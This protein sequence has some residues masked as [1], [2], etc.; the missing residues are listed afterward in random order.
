MDILKEELKVNKIRNLYLFY[1]PEEY[2]KKYYLDAI[3]KEILKNDFT[4][5]NRTV[6]ENKTDT[7]RIIDAVDTLPAFS[8]K[9]LVIVKNSGLLK[10]KKS[11][12][13]NEDAK[14]KG[15]QDELL[16]YLQNMPEFAVL[17]FYE[18]EVDKRIKL[19]DAIKKNGL[20]VEF[21]FQKP[22]ELVKWVVKVFK[23]F[24]KEIDTVTAS[25]LVENSEQGM[26]E[27]LNEI[28]KLISFVGNRNIITL[29]DV[30]AVCTKSIKSR[31]FDL[32]DAIAE[33]DGSKALKILNDMILLKEPVPKIL[34]MITR[35]IRQIL[36]MKLLHEGGMNANEA[37]AK[38][39]VMP[40]LAGK[41]LK[42]AGRF[43][44]EKLKAALEESLELDLSIKTGRIN[45]RIATE[46]FISEFQAK[47]K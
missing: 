19:V 13:G 17:V 46:L 38:I 21:Q 37:A 5:L 8:E 15:Q 20:I 2:L 26:N 1:G 34:F 36:E 24:K 3:E 35:Q 27:I 39:G 14:G 47:A 4:G 30:E 32:T 9:K 10:S 7:R 6:I 40:F 23:S 33:N 16:K 22:V 43:T 12:S 11:S 44:T 45:D 41:M 31:I 29:Q 28:N 25:N 42:Q 18:A